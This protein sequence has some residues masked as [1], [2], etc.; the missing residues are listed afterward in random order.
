LRKK[1]N[2]TKEKFR[3]IL[4]KDSSTIHKIDGRSDSPSMAQLRFAQHPVAPLA[5][6]VNRSGG[7][8]KGLMAP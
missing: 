5:N 6:F 7:N 4:P 2:G 8:K 1:R 3:P